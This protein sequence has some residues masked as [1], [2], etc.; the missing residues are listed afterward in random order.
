MIPRGGPLVKGTRSL[1]AD[2]LLGRN[3]CDLEGRA[4]TKMQDEFAVIRGVIDWLESRVEHEPERVRQTL[5][6]VNAVLRSHKK[7]RRKA[8]K[9]SRGVGF[10][11]DEAFIMTSLSDYEN[12]IES[13]A[14]AHW[15]SLDEDKVDA[16]LRR[17]Y[18]HKKDLE[19]VGETF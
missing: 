2:G 15:K 10:T 12:S 7:P 11:L 4:M 1:A 18:R 17:L 8:G 19:D 9:K 16:N 14:R 13:A 3:L 6:Q 5:L